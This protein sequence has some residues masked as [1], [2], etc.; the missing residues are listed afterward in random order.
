MPCSPSMLAGSSRWDSPSRAADWQ[1]GWQSA[2]RDPQGNATGSLWPHAKVGFSWQAALSM[3]GGG[4]V[5]RLDLPEE[6][7]AASARTALAAGLCQFG[8][9]ASS[10]PAELPL[11]R[12]AILIG[13]C[14]SSWRSGWQSRFA[15]AW[16][17]SARAAPSRSDGDNIPGKLER[18]TSVARHRVHALAALA[19]SRGRGKSFGRMTASLPPLSPV[20][21]GEGLG[22]RGSRQVAG[23]RLGGSP[24]PLTPTPLPRVQGRGEQERPPSRKFCHTRVA[25]RRGNWLGKGFKN[26]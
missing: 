14:R 10:Y 5:P 16:Q 1:A 17:S 12:I 18:L 15:T 19:V 23:E 9:Q 6:L 26:G 8:S 25:V 13:L 7:S 20:L 3:A 11:V 4:S 24:S 21:G 22:V 2:L